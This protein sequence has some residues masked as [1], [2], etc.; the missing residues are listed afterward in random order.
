[1][2]TDI[3]TDIFVYPSVSKDSQCETNQTKATNMFINRNNRCSTDLY[4]P[5]ELALDAIKNSVFITTDYPF[6]LIL[7]FEQFS[8]VE[9]NH[10]AGLLQQYFGDCLLCPPLP[11]WV[12]P[13]TGQVFANLE[14]YTHTQYLPSPELLKRRILLSVVQ[15]NTKSEHGAPLEPERTSPCGSQ[16]EVPDT[17]RPVHTLPLT[18]VLTDPE[19]EEKIPKQDVASV[20]SSTQ[21]TPSTPWII[22]AT[23]NNS[24]G[25]QPARSPLCES[26]QNRPAIYT[27]ALKKCH[28]TDTFQFHP[29]LARI[30][31]LPIPEPVPLL[32]QLLYKQHYLKNFTKPEISGRIL[33]CS[34]LQPDERSANLRRSASERISGANLSENYV[35]RIVSSHQTQVT[36]KPE[37]TNQLEIIACLSSLL[38]A[39]TIQLAHRIRKKR[40]LRR[41]FTEAY[42]DRSYHRKQN[43]SNLN[44]KSQGVIPTV[45]N[46]K[47]AQNSCTVENESKPRRGSLVS[48]IR[49][50]FVKRTTSP[51]NLSVEATARRPSLLSVTYDR[52]RRLSNLSLFGHN[53]PNPAKSPSN[54]TEST[55]SDFF[56]KFKTNQRLSFR[57]YSTNQ[58]KTED[59]T[60]RITQPVNSTQ[61]NRQSAF[62]AHQE[63]ST[64]SSHSEDEYKTMSKSNNKVSVS[65]RFGP[66]NS[67]E[68][69]PNTTTSETMKKSRS[70][71]KCSCSSGSRS[72]YGSSSDSLETS[73]KRQLRKL[74]PTT[75]V[76]KTNQNIAPLNRTESNYVRLEARTPNF[77]PINRRRTSSSSVS[78]STETDETSFTST[79]SYESVVSPCCQ[80]NHS[81]MLDS[82]EDSFTDAD[83][84]PLTSCSGRISGSKQYPSPRT[85]ENGFVC[86]GSNTKNVTANDHLD[87]NRTQWWLA[88]TQEFQN[89]V[90]FKET[91]IPRGVLW[92]R[93]NQ[94]LSRCR[95][96]ITSIRQVL[97]ILPNQTSTKALAEYCKTH[98]I[99]VTPASPDFNWQTR[100]LIR[101]VGCQLLALTISVPGYGSHLSEPHP[102]LS[103]RRQISQHYFMEQSKLKYFGK[104]TGYILKPAR[105]RLQTSV[106]VHRYPK[107]WLL[108][109]LPPTVPDKLNRVGSD[110]ASC[111]PPSRWNRWPTVSC[112]CCYDPLFEEAGPD[113][114]REL[115]GQ[116]LTKTGDF[117]AVRESMLPW[118]LSVQILRLMPHV[119][120]NQENQETR[121]LVKKTSQRKPSTPH[122]KKLPRRYQRAASS[123]VCTEKQ[124]RLHSS[125]KSIPNS[126]STE[127]ISHISNSVLSSEDTKSLPQKSIA[128]DL[129][130]EVDLIS[131]PEKI[132]RGVKLDYGLQFKSDSTFTSC[133][134]YPHGES[135]VPTPFKHAQTF[136]DFQSLTR[137]VQNSPR[138]EKVD[139][140][141]ILSRSCTSF[142]TSHSDLFFHSLG[143]QRFE[144]TH[145]SPPEM[146]VFKLRACDS[147]KS[148]EPDRNV[149]VSLEGNASPLDKTATGYQ[150][151][152]LSFNDNT[153][154]TSGDNVTRNRS[155]QPPFNKHCLYH[156]YLHNLLGM[157]VFCK[158]ELHVQTPASLGELVDTLSQE[159]SSRANSLNRQTASAT[160][161]ALP[162]SLEA[163]TSSLYKSQSRATS[164]L[165]LGIDPNQF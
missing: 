8:S 123:A 128:S 1:M 139:L 26:S 10:L 163:S 135:F 18:V 109:G 17:S 100:Q 29:R 125:P 69:Q 144:F 68:P 84:E 82:E 136:Q 162:K 152:R 48:G 132:T 67:N 122:S 71:A 110:E 146:T 61:S 21:I 111:L 124:P 164:L 46:S 5:L 63:S 96:V 51:T 7:R 31:S 2:R 4:V 9:Q 155:A 47:K 40:L 126:A 55:A 131:P 108:R 38:F 53:K 147:I 104:V 37:E 145:L 107:E 39:R 23:G 97:R 25:F 88:A 62:S 41:L 113:Y 58:H 138:T 30:I 142:H 32:C 80:R 117:V 22:N 90:P 112:T 78:T 85:Y 133:A 86:M 143:I 94:W 115:Y 91:I 159:Y 45:V 118:N 95:M 105:M 151:V 119:N 59:N 20:G 14:K 42:G 153:P 149:A 3:K 121:N 127:N 103:V 76:L 33:N 79:D 89:S 99:V 52:A 75:Q 24:R 49:T 27:S 160:N 34:L 93:T 13:S 116:R 72:S 36:N 70:F 114:M 35:G 98:L 154:M 165:R 12:E 43:K 54:T 15:L 74:N 101:S 134:N 140:H 19:G 64:S 87:L 6:L 83:D 129:K 102:T 92:R 16:D 65:R 137:L 77:A 161:L 66:Y 60:I 73:T 57:G 150:H 157:I 156:R 11:K 120:Y 81:G 50:W 28:A 158:I 141:G 106:Y 148:T 44:A 130:I 56:N